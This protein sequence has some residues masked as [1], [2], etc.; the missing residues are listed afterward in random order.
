MKITL[1]EKGGE[2]PIAVIVWQDNR[3]LIDA[4]DAILR[5]TL[6]ELYSKPLYRGR[7]VTQ[8]GFMGY[9]EIKLNPDE[10]EF[11]KETAYLL[12]EMSFDVCLDG[13]RKNILVALDFDGTIW[14]SE[15]ECFLV[16]CEAFKLIGWPLPA[17]PDLRQK[18]KRGRF[19]P[20]IG[21]EFYSII[22]WI[23]ENP[24]RDPQ[25]M[26]PEE[27]TA[28]RQAAQFDSKADRFEV[29][30]Y[31]V[32]QEWRKNDFA[33]WAAVQRPYPGII[34]QIR[35]LE[36]RFS[37]VMIAT[38]KFADS[39]QELLAT[40]GLRLD[41]IGKEKTTDK[42]KQMI[43]LSKTYKKTF[44]E[45]IFV[46]DLLMQVKAVKSLGANV[47]LAG[48]GYSSDRQKEEAKGL[49]IPVLKLD[50][51]EDSLIKLF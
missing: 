5:K 18:F 22:Q 12:Q 42:M 1:F 28:L 30:F 49:N 37:K 40:Q 25:S 20:A 48:W 16:S 10:E 43:Q 11:F 46:D 21:K 45:M 51:F 19:F 24:Q 47:A 9:Q 35:V 50:S 14:D 38:T 8:D 17:I 31:Q 44:R 29:A 15:E 33:G 4:S 32:R 23:G 7:S 39:A 41:A 2:T 34:D 13:E 27:E 3:A 26:T 6:A 36:K